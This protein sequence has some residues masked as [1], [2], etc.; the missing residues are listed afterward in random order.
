MGQFIDQVQKSNQLV[1]SARQQKERE[2]QQRKEIEKKLFDYFFQQL[3]AP[4]E[5]TTEKQYQFLL[6]PQ[7]FENFYNE[8]KKEFL[9]LGFNKK[10]IYD[11]YIKILN[12]LYSTFKKSNRYFQKDY[13]EKLYITISN[14]YEK[15]GVSA[16][17]ILEEAKREI[18]QRIKR[19]TPTEDIIKLISFYDSQN[20]KFYKLY[21]PPKNHTA[22][23]IRW[24]LYLGI[25]DIIKSSR[26]NKRRH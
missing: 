24:G 15:H 7:T 11:L 20:N 16:F 8:S 1:I 3:K 12:N 13:K 9:N 10:T 19:E 2:K 26:R 23:A 6:L 22:R 25:S 18:M 5:G 4:E 21:K 14:A 17:W